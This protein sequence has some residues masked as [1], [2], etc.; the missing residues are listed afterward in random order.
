MA[1]KR[2]VRKQLDMFPKS[3][4][5]SEAPGAKHPQSGLTESWCPHEPTEERYGHAVYCACG[6]VLS[7]CNHHRVLEPIE[8]PGQHCHTCGS[9]AGGRG[10]KREAPSYLQ[11]L[12]EESWNSLLDYAESISDTLEEVSPPEDD[13]GYE[14]SEDEGNDGVADS[15][16]WRSDGEP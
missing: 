9:V 14:P 3:K 6:M 13:L 10:G 4:A 8:S 1:G 12:D 11:D 7:L 2:W 5:R 15:D 16:E